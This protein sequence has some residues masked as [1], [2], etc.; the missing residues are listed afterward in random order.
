MKKIYSLFVTAFLLLLCSPLHAQLNRE[1][2]K[3]TFEGTEGART[4]S[5]PNFKKSSSTSRTQ[6]RTANPRDMGNR[7]RVS[8]INRRTYTS[9]STSGSSAQVRGND[10]TQ[11]WANIGTTLMGVVALSAEQARADR[12]QAMYRGRMM[13]ARRAEEERM[14]QEQFKEET[15]DLQTKLRGMDVDTSASRS[16]AGNPL[17]LRLSAQVAQAPKDM[18]VLPDLTAKPFIRKVD[19]SAE[20]KSVAMEAAYWFSDNAHESLGMVVQMMKDL[21]YAFASNRKLEEGGV[22]FPKPYPGSAGESVLEWATD[23]KKGKQGLT[24]AYYISGYAMPNIS[25]DRYRVYAVR[26]IS[27]SQPD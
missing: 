2:T 1:N 25:R 26:F 12:E 17:G 9:C 14:R 15:A 13:A 24:S 7:N 3:A 27:P 20:F 18:A 11:T 16:L 10:H 23:T 5:I 19:P 21:G 8:G 6:G 4:Y 22:I